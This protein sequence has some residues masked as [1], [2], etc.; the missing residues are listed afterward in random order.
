MAA[1]NKYSVKLK[2]QAVVYAGGLPTDRAALVTGPPPVYGQDYRHY[3]R[4]A[5]R[6]RRGQP[7]ARARRRILIMVEQ[8]LGEFGQLHA[9][10]SP[11]G[12]PH[13][14]TTL[15]HPIASAFP[16][17]RRC[18]II[19]MPG[20][21]AGID[22]GVKVALGMAA[23]DTR[24]RRPRRTCSLSTRQPRRP[25]FGPSAIRS[26]RLPCDRRGFVVLGPQ[27][28]VGNPRSPDQCRQFEKGHL[29]RSFRNGR[30]GGKAAVG[31]G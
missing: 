6:A 18:R 11:L 19:R 23:V 4:G 27:M 9:V 26:M 21:G 14:Q 20:R 10:A 1:A 13:P 24:P 3:L 30:Q 17:G 22:Q 31:P 15:H 25:R 29:R 12:Q 2:Q 7:P 28:G 16:C 8:I 5:G